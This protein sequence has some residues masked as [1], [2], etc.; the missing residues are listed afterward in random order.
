MLKM[1]PAAIVLLVGV[2]TTAHAQQP[3]R[4]QR[5]GSMVSQAPVKVARSTKSAALQT[6]SR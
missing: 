2:L 4:L 1:I 6:G 3:H 5:F